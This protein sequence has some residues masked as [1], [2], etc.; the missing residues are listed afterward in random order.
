MVERCEHTPKKST[1][2]EL[3]TTVS[4]SKATEYKVFLPDNISHR[5]YIVPKYYSVFAA[6]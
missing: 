3:R 1:V 5:D 6:L 4:L 2:I